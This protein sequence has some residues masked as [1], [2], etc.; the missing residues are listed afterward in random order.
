MVKFHCERHDTAIPLES[1]TLE[2]STMKSSWS[3]IRHFGT[4]FTEQTGQIIA[5]IHCEIGRADKHKV[6]L[7]AQDHMNVYPK[8]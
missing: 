2:M 4:T 1:R 3:L 8:N 6:E 5:K 7:S